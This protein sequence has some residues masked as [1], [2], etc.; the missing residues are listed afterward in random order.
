M[1]KMK[2]NNDFKKQKSVASFFQKRKMETKEGIKKIS[3][4]EEM[5]ETKYFYNVYIKLI[6]SQ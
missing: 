3:C 6:L 1:E 4:K 5:Y 2:A